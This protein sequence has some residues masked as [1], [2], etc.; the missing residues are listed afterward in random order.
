MW[1][2]LAG[3]GSTL[4]LVSAGVIF[5]QSRAED[6]LPKP[7]AVVARDLNMPL[8]GDPPTAPSADAKTREEK[9]FNRLD[10]DKNEAID[11]PEYF[12]SRQKAFAKLDANRDG[13]LSFDEW[14]VKAREKFA[15]AD[16]DRSGRL[17]RAEFATTAVVR[18]AKPKP[19]CPPQRAA[20]AEEDG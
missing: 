17:T 19:D 6:S 15:K 11:A 4:L 16:G 9:R 7:A 1:R 2:F 5:W 3:V 13:R 10:K 12:T 20:A 14:A 18:K 8:L